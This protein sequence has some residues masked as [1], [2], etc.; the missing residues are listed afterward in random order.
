MTSL[1]R[2]VVLAALSSLA[3]ACGPKPVPLTAELR[4]E[5][6]L[7]AEE[8]RRLQLYVSHDVTLRRESARRER[9][10]DGGA[11]RLRS[12]RTVDEIVI[13]RRTPCIATEVAPRG[14]TVAFE[15]GST[16]RFELP[17]A[18]PDEASL[19]GPLRLEPAFAAPPEPGPT[20]PWP[21]L[22]PRSEAAYS[23]SVRGGV[24]EHR[25][26]AWEPIGESLRAELLVATEE[27]DETEEQRRIVGG[28]R[29]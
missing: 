12:G 8:L 25:G 11:L 17:G 1:S 19:R 21:E 14:I 29:L 28:R 16:L 4:R 7:G 26:L 27:L 15:D 9:A 24:V 18:L 22:A 3:L 10:I 23:L 6:G 20:S 5:H 13:P 2:H